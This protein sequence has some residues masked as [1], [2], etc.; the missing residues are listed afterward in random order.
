MSPI[1]GDIMYPALADFLQLLAGN[2][3]DEQLV[4]KTRQKNKNPGD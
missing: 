3:R 2:R 4:K 1:I